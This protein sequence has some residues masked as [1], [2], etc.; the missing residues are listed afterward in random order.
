MICSTVELAIFDDM[1][2]E[3]SLGAERKRER[4]LQPLNLKNQIIF[5]E[6]SRAPSAGL[7][8]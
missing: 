5:L 8:L 2:L 4:G 3:M 7:S 1:R 6:Y